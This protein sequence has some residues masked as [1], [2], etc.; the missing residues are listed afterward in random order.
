MA[1]YNTPDLLTESDA[2]IQSNVDNIDIEYYNSGVSDVVKNKR[3]NFGDML[4]NFNAE[5]GIRLTSGRTAFQ[6]ITSGTL[7]TSGWYTI[8]EFYGSGLTARSCTA[9]ITVEG[10][11]EHGTVEL[12][13]YD[14]SNISSKTHSNQH[15]ELIKTHADKSIPFRVAKSDTAALT[16]MKIQAY[17]TFGSS[18]TV[19]VILSSN[20]AR[21]SQLG[22]EL[23]TP[24]LDN[25]PTLSDGVTA[26]TFLVAGEEFLFHDSS[27]VHPIPTISAISSDADTLRVTAIWPEIP[28][29]GTS[30]SIEGVSTFTFTDNA[31]DTTAALSTY[32]ISN[33]Q[34]VV[35][36]VQFRINQTGIATGIN[37]YYPMGLI[38]NGTV[39]LKIS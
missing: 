23:V 25:T 28:Y 29:N 39:K 2:T 24:Y 31:D 8:A 15:I 32:T 5:N 9:E 34:I 26:G 10:R 20:V 4:D 18:E 33:L 19:N 3:G 30:L 14:S 21:L 6:E 35:K 27:S 7:S 1:N 17:L 16:G 22:I 37:T 13:L 12:A 36:T 11:F 38:A